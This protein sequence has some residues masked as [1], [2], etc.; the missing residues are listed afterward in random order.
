MQ[1]K[2]KNYM[3]SSL[4]VLLLSLDEYADAGNSKLM[5]HG[6]LLNM[7]YLLYG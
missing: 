5:W 4:N 6:L 7:P 1:L 2:K 3:N